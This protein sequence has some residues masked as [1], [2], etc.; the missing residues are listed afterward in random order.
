[1]GILDPK[2][3]RRGRLER[4]SKSGR[5]STAMTAVAASKIHISKSSLSEGNESH[6]NLGGKRRR[7][8]NPLQ[9]FF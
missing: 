7:R 4:R 9:S 3:V 5:N 1:V 8:G 6:N 2:A